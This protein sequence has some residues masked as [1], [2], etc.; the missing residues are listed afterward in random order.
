MAS[1]ARC[2]DRYNVCHQRRLK[3]CSIVDNRVT[4]HCA[5]LRLGRYLRRCGL[6]R[7]LWA[8]V[9]V[10]SIYLTS[11]Q[12]HDNSQ[13][14]AGRS[15]FSDSDPH[16]SRQ[17][18]FPYTRSFS[19]E[20]I[21]AL[22]QKLWR[23]ITVGKQPLAKIHNISLS[24]HGLASAGT[25]Q[26]LIEGFFASSEGGSA[27]PDESSSKKRPPAFA[28]DE[29]EVESE[30]GVDTAH[31]M[32]QSFVCDKCS[33]RISLPSPSPDQWESE[34]DVERALELLKM[35]HADY[36][37]AREL[38]QQVSEGDDDAADV[39]TTPSKPPR[40]KKKT[41]ALKQSQSSSSRQ[42]EAQGIARYF[43]ASSSSTS[44]SATAK[45]SRGK[46]V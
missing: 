17:Y 25:G 13:I 18:P 43:E 4:W 32:R 37:F 24:F 45:R 36:H 42:K 23:E 22:A 9:K 1:H 11:R 12:R 8:F 10:S 44:A 27:R 41:T 2:T 38:A 40:K 7:L 21:V 31:D 35:E 39:Q 15:F 34:T 6:R 29:D 26:K 5:S 20:T 46:R 14:C 16:K 33:K 3:L 19:V 28:D 30:E